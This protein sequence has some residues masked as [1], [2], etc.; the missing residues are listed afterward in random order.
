[1]HETYCSFNHAFAETTSPMSTCVFP[2]AQLSRTRGGLKKKK[3]KKFGKESQEFVSCEIWQD[4]R[5]GC[6]AKLREHWPSSTD[7]DGLTQQSFYRWT[8][9]KDE[10]LT[11]FPS[12]LVPS[13]EKTHTGFQPWLNPCWNGRSLGC[14]E[15]IDPGGKRIPNLMVTVK[16]C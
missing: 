10:E 12:P 2:A 14:G 16:R 6:R 5:P 3:K 7:R 1:M 13:R 9:D 8:E 11:R 15:R 4:E